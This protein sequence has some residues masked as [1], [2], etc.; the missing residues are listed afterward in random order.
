M[1]YC[2]SPLEK[3]I[4]SDATRQALTG[5]AAKR[6]DDFQAYLDQLT[7]SFSGKIARF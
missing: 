1:L 2:L 4:L 6:M 7:S 5:L 3:G